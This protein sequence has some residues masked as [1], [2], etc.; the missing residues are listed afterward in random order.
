MKDLLVFR[1]TKTTEETTAYGIY[2]SKELIKI[3]HTEIDGKLY[4]QEWKYSNNRLS[5]SAQYPAN[6]EYAENQLKMYQGI[7][8]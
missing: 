2:T 8:N 5:H 4:Q 3:E 7:Y 6:T 1:G